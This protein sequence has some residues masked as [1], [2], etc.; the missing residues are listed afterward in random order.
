MINKK[1]TKSS[2][3]QRGNVGFFIKVRTLC[4]YVHTLCIIQRC[5]QL[6]KA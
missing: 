2:I 4:V 5:I 1:E 6:E 3:E